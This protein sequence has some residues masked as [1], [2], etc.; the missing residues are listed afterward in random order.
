LSGL[1]IYLLGAPRIER[2]G[3]VIAGPRG[4][5]AWGLLAYLLLSERPPTRDELVSLLFSEADDPFAAL[6]WNLSALRRGLG[7]ARLEGDPLRLSLPSGTIVDLQT[8]MSGSWLDALRV[9]GVDGSC[10]QA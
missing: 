10:S 3:E 6:R 9:A 4:Y 1:A 8:L 7:D 5:K 2:D